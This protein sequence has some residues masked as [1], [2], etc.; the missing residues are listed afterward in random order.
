VEG[1]RENVKTNN[2]KLVIWQ[3]GAKKDTENSVGGI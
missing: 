3:I 2:T 1:S